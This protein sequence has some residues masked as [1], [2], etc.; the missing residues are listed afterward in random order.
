[1]ISF[2]TAD[3]T[4]PCHFCRQLRE[5][6]K[7]TYSEP[8]LLFYI[9]T[10]KDSMWPGGVLAESLPPKTEAQKFETRMAAKNKLL[11][12]IPGNS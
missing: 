1:M 12:N 4:C 3:L 6:V 7:W 8:M 9:R 2:L 11:Q 10:F 5:M